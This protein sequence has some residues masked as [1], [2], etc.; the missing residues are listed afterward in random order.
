MKK[1]KAEP[2]GYEVVLLTEFSTNEL[3]L[4]VARCHIVTAECVMFFNN[5]GNSMF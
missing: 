4:L 1:K 3:Q 2:N 5:L